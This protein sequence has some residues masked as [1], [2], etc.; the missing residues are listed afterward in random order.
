MSELIIDWPGKAKTVRT[1]P[2]AAVQ[3]LLDVLSL[4][5]PAMPPPIREWQFMYPIRE[6]AFDLAWPYSGAG[7]AIEVDGGVWSGGRHNTGTGF[8]EDC[9]KLAAATAIGWKVVRIPSALLREN[10]AHQD[11]NKVNLLCKA[12]VMSTD[13]HHSRWGDGFAGIAGPRYNP[14]AQGPWLKEFADESIK[15]KRASKKI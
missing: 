14:S 9:V 12:G 6:W 8:T 1:S 3:R 11:W 13:K 4:T 15:P 10:L 7:L 5:Y 2:S